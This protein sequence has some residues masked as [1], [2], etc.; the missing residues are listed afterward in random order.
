[1]GKIIS[2]MNSFKGF[3]K[4]SELTAQVNAAIKTLFD[5]GKIDEL[6]KKYGFE[7]VVQLVEKID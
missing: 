6:A 7:N 2:F 4:G 5:N 3:A 1:M